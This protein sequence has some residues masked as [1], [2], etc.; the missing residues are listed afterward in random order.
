MGKN[1]SASG[2][3]NIIQYDNA[4]NISFVSGSTTLLAISS[5]G[6]VTT[7]GVISGSDAANAV[8]A[9]YA[10]AATSASFASVAT[11]ASF[12]TTS[13]TSSF[14]NNLT[15]N[16]TITAQTLNVQQVTSS[17][18]YSSGSNV[19]G[20]SLANTQV[21]T[22]SVSMTGSLSVGGALTGTTGTF[23]TLVR[24]GNDVEAWNGQASFTAN[25]MIFWNTNNVARFRAGQTSTQLAMTIG[26]VDY[27]RM[28]TTGNVIL[29]SGG[30]FTD[31]GFKLDVQGTGRFT[32]A[33]SG[34][35]ATFSDNIT[36]TNAGRPYFIAKTTNSGEEAGIKIQQSTV[37]DWYIG[38]AQGTPSAQDL[39]IRD[40]KNGRIP[41][42]LSASTGAATFSSSVTAGGSLNINNASTATPALYVNQNGNNNDVIRVNMQ[43]ASTY[44]LRVLW[45]DGANASGI[46]V[47]SVG[48]AVSYNTSFSDFRKKKNFEKW[49]ENVLGYFKDINPKLFNFDFQS[50]DSEK[51]K[52][53][54]AQ[55]MVDKFPEAYPISTDGFYS[56]NPSGMIVY[57]MKAI[58]EQQQQ[59]EELKALIAAK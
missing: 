47:N 8:S 34:T 40:V 33:L 26:S 19:F 51:T 17:V 31:A 50:N 49:D 37:S 36:I 44:V 43:N 3:T 57:L 5:S 24:S 39:A 42:Y 16:G 12:A 32:G 11:S 55:E 35:S 29:Q 45:Y 48:S 25:S 20:N 38:T 56:F 10:Q 2:L 22:G 28:F 18:I 9:S 58:Q 14:A 23:S 13:L 4:G 27:L 41:F 46:Q 6:T 7:T 54:I 30:T 53:F 21:F 59:I 52:G 1:Q 15:V